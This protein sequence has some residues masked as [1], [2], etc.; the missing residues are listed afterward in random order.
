M[1][2]TLTIE[3]FGLDSQFLGF[4]EKVHSA[5]SLHATVGDVAKFVKHTKRIAA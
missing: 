1:A 4:G 5:R 3:E 2:V